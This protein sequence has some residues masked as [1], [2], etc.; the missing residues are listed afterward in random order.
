MRGSRVRAFAALVALVVLC[1]AP[2]MQTGGRRIAIADL[3]AIE[4]VYNGNPLR[5][6][7]DPPPLFA[8][9]YRLR[10]V[11]APLPADSGARTVALPRASSGRYIASFDRVWET[12]RRLYPTGSGF[13]TT[14]TCASTPALR[15]AVY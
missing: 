5:N 10:F 11:D 13:S 6:Q 8:E 15:L 7:D 3:P 1:A 12:L 4:P 2:T 9:A 14:I